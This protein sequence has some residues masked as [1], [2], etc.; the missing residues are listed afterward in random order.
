MKVIFA[1]KNKE[2]EVKGPKSAQSLAK[3]LGISLEANVFIKNGEIV[4][5]DDVLNDDDVVEVISAVS[6]G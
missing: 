2:I 6:G 1:G 5:P 4:A 3:D